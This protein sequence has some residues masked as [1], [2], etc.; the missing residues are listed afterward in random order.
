MS[1]GGD[2]TQIIRMTEQSPSGMAEMP[3]YPGE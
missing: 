1:S 3:H 2:S